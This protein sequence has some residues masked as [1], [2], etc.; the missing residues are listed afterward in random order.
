MDAI[1]QAKLI[2]IDLQILI[3]LHKKRNES[4]QDG[5]QIFI[6]TPILQIERTMLESQEPICHTDPEWQP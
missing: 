3:L 4:D 1:V 2:P 6:N 5:I